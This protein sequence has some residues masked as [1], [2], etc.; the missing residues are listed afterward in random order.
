MRIYPLIESRTAPYAAFVS[1]RKIPV[2]SGPV[3]SSCMTPCKPWFPKSHHGESQALL[4]S[5]VLI[6]ESWHT[7]STLMPAG[8]STYAAS[9]NS[10]RGSGFGCPAVR[11]RYHRPSVQLGGALRFALRPDYPEWYTRHRPGGSGQSRSETHQSSA[12]PRLQRLPRGC[13][14]DPWEYER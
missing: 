2:L 3:V 13:P 10:A 9:H 6:V 7:T 5:R 4:P 14:P 8:S 1:F 11:C 12:K